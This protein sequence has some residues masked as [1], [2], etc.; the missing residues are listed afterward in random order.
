MIDILKL[1]ALKIENIPFSLEKK[2]IIN[3][4]FFEELLVSCE[5][6][7]NEKLLRYLVDV[8]ENF[9]RYIYFIISNE[10]LNSYLNNKT[11]LY[12]TIINADF[13]YVADIDE[14]DEIIFTYIINKEFLPLKYLPNE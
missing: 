1:G 10:N 12:N 3:D 2:Q 11:S 8:D 9:I 13:Y 7:S 14:N 6:N 5:I 4:V